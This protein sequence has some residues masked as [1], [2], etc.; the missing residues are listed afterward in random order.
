VG[1]IL[2]SEAKENSLREIIETFNR[3]DETSSNC[4]TLST[5]RRTAIDAYVALTTNVLS[6]VRYQ[7]KC[8]RFAR[9]PTEKHSGEI[10]EGF[11][12]H[13]RKGRVPWDLGSGPQERLGT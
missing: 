8:I 9:S 7:K 4:L 13:L 3:D 6:D 1:G 2:R 10:R 12:F 5:L 11:L